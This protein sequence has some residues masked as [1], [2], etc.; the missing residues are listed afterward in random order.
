MRSGRDRGAKINCVEQFGGA[1]YSHSVEIIEWLYALGMECSQAFLFRTLI[2]RP[3]E[4]PK[5]HSVSMCIL[6]DNNKLGYLVGC[7]PASSTKGRLAKL[8]EE[9][10]NCSLQVGSLLRRHY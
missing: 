9:P 10:S 3:P 7:L 2:E 8:I 5:N 6:R 4:S 1:S